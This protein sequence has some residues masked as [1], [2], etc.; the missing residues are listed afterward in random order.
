MAKKKMPE[1]EKKI[2]SF[3]V[4]QDR[5]DAKYK[6]HTVSGLLGTDSELLPC[7]EWPSWSVKL[8]PMLR[9]EH[10][11][12]QCHKLFFTLYPPLRCIDHAGTEPLN[13]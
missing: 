4:M 13:P 11:C 7:P 1:W 5:S 12:P 9:E 8:A 3:D 10:L 6:K 2:H